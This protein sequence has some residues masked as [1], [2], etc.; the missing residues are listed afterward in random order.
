MDLFVFERAI[1]TR[2]GYHTHVQCVP[3]PKGLGVKLETTLRAQAKANKIDLREIQSPDLDIST[4]LSQNEDEGDGG[5]FYAEVPMPGRQL[6]FKRFLFQV[7]AEEQEG[8]RGPM[9]PIQFGREVI[10]AVLGKSELAHWK[11]CQVDK[12]EETKMAADLRQ[13]FEKYYDVDNS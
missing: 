12:E 6:E 5:Y 9:V 13:S 3:V 7:R 8:N 10:A 4:L 2:G 1:Q 11:S